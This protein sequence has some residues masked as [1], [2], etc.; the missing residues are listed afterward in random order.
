MNVR[1]LVASL[2][3]Q[4]DLAGIAQPRTEARDIVAAL[5][6]VSRWW[7]ASNP[8]AAVD[9]DVAQRAHSAAE[10]R[11]HG[12]PFAYAVGRAAFRWMTLTVDRRVLIPRQ[13]TEILVEI[14]LRELAA[15]TG[16][17]AVDVGT[18]SGAIALAL[19]T[20][21]RLDRIVATDISDDALAVAALNIERLKT[22]LLAPVELRQGGGLAP[23]LDGPPMRAVVSNPPYIAHA[24]EPELPAAVR[25]WEP[26][27]ALYSADDGMQATAELIRDA[28]TVL[29]PGGLLAIEVD[30]RRAQRAAE[31]ARS[32]RRYDAVSIDRDLSGRDRILTARRRASR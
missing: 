6:D 17:T 31:L 27:V 25:D 24:E 18:G 32:D 10:R 23:V 3:S 9:S 5:L 13:E 15:T 7:P 11:A 2:E 22:Q 28:A 14:V 30:S 1:E 29:E 16:G 19:A 20:E 21:S 12:E 26:P 8:D 4:L